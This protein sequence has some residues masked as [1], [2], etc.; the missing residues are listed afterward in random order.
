[1]ARGGGGWIGAYGF[2]R[3]GGECAVGG[4]YLLGPAARGGYSRGGRSRC[5]RIACERVGAERR[6]NDAVVE[7]YLGTRA[8]LEEVVA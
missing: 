2:D 3:C 8:D 1:M 6:S 4:G 7:A 5:G